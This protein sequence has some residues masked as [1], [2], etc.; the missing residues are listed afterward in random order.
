MEIKF[1][2]KVVVITG[3]TRGIGKG[4][5]E[6]FYDSG[7]TLILTGAN[8]S[9]IEKLNESVKDKKR[10][11]YF[12]LDLLNDRS[13]KT[14][15]SKMRGYSRIDVCINNAGINKIGHIYDV[16]QKDW[17]DIVKVNLSGPFLLCKELG[18]IMKKRRYGRIVNIASIFSEITRE[19][20]AAYTATKSGLVGL[21]RTVSLD[22]APYNVL[23]NSVSPGFI[24]TDLTKRILKK[25]EI[26]SLKNSI[27][28]GRLGTPEDI[29]S[30]VLFLASDINT[31]ITGQNIVA[32]GGYVNI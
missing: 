9:K 12:H 22:L 15:V 20:R 21:T 14:F 23:V 31:Y 30:L 26:S 7:A 4:I 2:N 18:K 1:K 6:R 19:K 29:A 8:K 5:A 25:V 16:D 10:I 17:D 3:A 24:L 13:I 27:P 32:D 11:K 28:L